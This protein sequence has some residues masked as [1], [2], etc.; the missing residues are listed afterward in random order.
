MTDLASCDFPPSDMKWSHALIPSLW[1]ILLD[2]DLTW[3]KVTKKRLRNT[4]LVVNFGNKIR[5]IF[6]VR[7]QR[8]YVGHKYA[9][10]IYWNIFSKWTTTWDNMPTRVAK[11]KFWIQF[12][13][14]CFW[15]GIKYWNSIT[16]RGSNTFS[17]LF[18]QFN[19]F[20]HFNYVLS[21]LFLWIFIKFF[22]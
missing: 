11:G 13:S 10:N 22:L 1:G 19:V 21:K 4:F 2:S 18:W 9:V 6:N 16:C 20:D 8:F 17:G 7:R 15:Q 14:M 12:F 5:C 3:S